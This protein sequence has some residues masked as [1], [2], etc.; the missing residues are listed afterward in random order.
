MAGITV[1]SCWGHSGVTQ[2][3]ERGHSHRVRLEQRAVCF[4]VSRFLNLNLNSN[5]MQISIFK[6]RML[7][8]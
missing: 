2:S 6:M 5:L 7:K 4:L 1:M 3:S 8:T